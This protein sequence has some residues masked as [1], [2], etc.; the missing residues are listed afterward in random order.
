M[1]LLGSY[2]ATANENKNKKKTQKIFLYP[3]RNNWFVPIEVIFIIN[4]VIEF[5]LFLVKKFHWEFRFSFKKWK[6]CIQYAVMHP[7]NQQ[8]M[9]Y[10]PFEKYLKNLFTSK[11]NSV[12]SILGYSTNFFNWH[13]RHKH[14]HTHMNASVCGSNRKFAP[15]F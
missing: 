6:Q 5:S 12:A 11:S 15:S 14:A 2:L 4:Y 10:R 8:Q 13:S 7:F 9:L 1:N 3:K